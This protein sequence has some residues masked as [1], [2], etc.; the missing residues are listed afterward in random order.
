MGLQCTIGLRMLTHVAD[1]NLLDSR[2]G[3]IGTLDIQ[4]QLHGTLVVDPVG[5]IVQARGIA[6]ELALPITEL[7]QH[8]NIVVPRALAL[9]GTQPERHHRLYQ[10]S[11]VQLACVDHETF[12]LSD[13][14]RGIHI[15]L[16]RMSHIGHSQEVACQRK[17]VR[18]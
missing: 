9:L 2:K 11:T 13:W 12:V 15:D 1:G 6:V 10:R 7:A 17:H 18:L 14:Q 5:E 16:Q 8:G 4:N 3:R